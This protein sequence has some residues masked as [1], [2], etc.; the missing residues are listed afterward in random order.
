MPNIISL[1]I[2]F[3]LLGLPYITAASYVLVSTM[4]LLATVYYYLQLK[5]NLGLDEIHLEKAPQLPTSMFT[6]SIISMMVNSTAGIALF[7][8]GYT[9][10]FWY[11][12][13]WLVLGSIVSLINLCVHKGWITYTR[14]DKDED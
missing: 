3:V 4:C 2:V 13:P 14:K 6:N 1:F 11:M 9:S 12:F 7:I 10:V 8:I 5:L